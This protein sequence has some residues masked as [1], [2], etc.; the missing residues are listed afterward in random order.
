MTIPDLLPK[1]PGFQRRPDDR[2]PT[3]TNFLDSIAI[4]SEPTGAESKN[5]D[6]LLTF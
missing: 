5:V 2:K 1:Q 6:H 3:A 4:W